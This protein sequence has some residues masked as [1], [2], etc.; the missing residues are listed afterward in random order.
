VEPLDCVDNV[1]SGDNAAGG[2]GG[3]R[4]ESVCQHDSCGGQSEIYC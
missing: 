4:I 2:S 3:G 1:Y